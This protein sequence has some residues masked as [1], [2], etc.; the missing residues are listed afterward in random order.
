MGTKIKTKTFYKKRNNFSEAHYQLPNQCGMF[1]IDVVK[2]QWLNLDFESSQE[3]ATYI[4]YRKLKNGNGFERFDLDT[5]K[6]IALFELKYKRSD[7]L[8]QSFIDFKPG[9]VPWA[10]LMFCKKTNMRFFLVIATNGKPP[11]KFIEFT[12][13]G[14]IIDPINILDFDNNNVIKNINIFWE[15]KIKLSK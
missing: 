4:E 7:A 13:K 8:V 3:E 14:E 10:E 11:Y 2:A 1:D 6:P 9:G 15:K 12:M 5:F